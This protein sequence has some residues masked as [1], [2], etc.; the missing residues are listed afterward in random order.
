[1][2]HYGAGVSVAPT[3]KSMEF[4][5]VYVMEFK[6]EKIAHLTKIWNDSV[7]LK[8]VGWA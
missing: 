2:A 8:E 3:G 7:A 4:D 6:G 1:M 5:Y